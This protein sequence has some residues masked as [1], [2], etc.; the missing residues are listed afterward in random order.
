MGAETGEQN[1]K[2]P[3]DLASMASLPAAASK[4]MRS[5]SDTFQMG[6]RRTKVVVRVPAT[7]ANLGPG[8]DALGMAVDIWNEITVERADT[9]SVDA[10]G[11]GAA[12]IPREVGPNGETK[13]LVMQGLRRAFEYAGETLPPVHVFTRNRVPI[14]SGFGSSS[15]AIVGGLVAG[16]VLCGKELRVKDGNA[17][18]DPEELLHIATEMEGHPDNVAPAIYGGIQLSVQFE[19]QLDPGVRNTVMSRRVPHPAG[20][21]LVAYVPSEEARLASGLEKTE[22]M[23]NLL[24]PTIPRSDAVFN[25]Q[26]TALLINSLHAG[27]LSALRFGTRDRLHQ[28]MRGEHKYPHLD[29]MV[30]AAIEAGA[31]GCFLSGAGPTVM[32]ICSG[33]S[34]DIF[35][36]RSTERQEGDVARAM[37]RSL[38]QLSEAQQK[39]WGNG[40]FYI[41]SPTTHGAHVVSAEPKFSD[42]LAT[43]GSL[44]G[45]V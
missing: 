14:C 28:P 43:F 25:I 21:R 29:K 32:A 9:F 27:D 35:T 10:E 24:K 8:F 5:L 40:K 33:A 36:Q 44:D 1:G 15:S 22:E 34:G 2:R 3:L 42:Q 38:E 20:L 16:L 41:V 30:K 26:R 37:K 45:T 17:A 31:H 12:L 19:Q 23:R 18:V 7:S 4:K 39:M 6:E 11:E 13:H